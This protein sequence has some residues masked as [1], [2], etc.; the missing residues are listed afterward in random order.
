MNVRELERSIEALRAESKH[1]AEAAALMRTKAASLVAEA[2][3]C[4]NTAA[5]HAT[6]AEVAG[7]QADKLERKLEQYRSDPFEPELNHC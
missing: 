2:A 3:F 7:V 4:T 6:A 1:K 5:M